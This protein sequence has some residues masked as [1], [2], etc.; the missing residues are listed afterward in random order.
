MAALVS[1][2]LTD[3]ATVKEELGID[4]G[5]TSQDNK[6][7]RKINLVTAMIEGYCGLSA[8]HHFKQTTYTNEEY[9]GTG[10]NQLVLRMSPVI[11]ISSFQ[12]RDTSQNEDDWSDNES[13]QYFSNLPTGIIDLLWGQG[14]SWNS[15]R[16]TY[17]AGYATIPAD[18]AEACVVLASYLVTNTGASTGVKKKQ[19]G[20]RSIE[21]FDPGQSADSPIEQLGIDDMLSRYIRY[22]V[23]DNIA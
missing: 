10:S 12:R 18:L 8:D 2:A 3:V 13:E 21:Y 6:I 7:I 22:N 20:Q 9:D 11:S 19:E 4:A 17:I 23:A 1:W 16:I 14:S 15:Y 5:D